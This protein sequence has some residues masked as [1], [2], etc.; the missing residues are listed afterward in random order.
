MAKMIPPYIH[1]DVKSQAEKKV[2][3]LI[4]N[5]H[6]LGGW[7]CLHSLGLAHH[8]SKSEGEIDFLLIGPPGV[9]SLEVKDCGKS[10]VVF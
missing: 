2:Y 6:F 1:R 9:F 8:I 7:I 3:S 5:E 10:Q 4:E